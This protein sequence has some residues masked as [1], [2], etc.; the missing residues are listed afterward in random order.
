MKTRAILLAW[1]TSGVQDCFGPRRIQGVLR[2]I[3]FVCPVI[4]RKNAAGNAGLTPKQIT[5]KRFAIRGKGERLANF[6][7][8]EDGIFEIEAEIAEI[9]PGALR[10]CQAVLRREDGD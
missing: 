7:L 6:L 4:G 2:D 9:C 5:N 8:G 1:E 3:R 10:D